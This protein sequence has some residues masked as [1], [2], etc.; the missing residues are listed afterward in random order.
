ML[1]PSIQYSSKQPLRPQGR[2]YYRGAAMARERTSSAVAQRIVTMDGYR[3]DVGYCLFAARP[4][5]L[6]HAECKPCVALTGTRQSGRRR[7]VVGRRRPMSPGR[8]QRTTRHE[9]EVRTF[10][11]S[12]ASS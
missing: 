4:A 11:R 5:L 9:L 10:F 7:S 6:A 8:R 3:G 1:C 12:D 2:G